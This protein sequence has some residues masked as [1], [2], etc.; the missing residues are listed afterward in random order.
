MLEY[1]IINCPAINNTKS[2]LPP[3]G[4]T[5][6]NFQSFKRII[7]EPSII[8]S[9]FKCILIPLADKSDD[10]TNNENYQNNIVCCMVLNWYVLINNIEQYSK[11][12]KTYFDKDAIEN[13]ITFIDD[14]INESDYCHKLKENLINFLLW[15]KRI[16]KIL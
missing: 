13:F 16:T 5:Y 7:K 4:N 6:L 11:P 10:G 2:V 1:Q 14:V 9:G 3:E 12:C 8:Y 15:P